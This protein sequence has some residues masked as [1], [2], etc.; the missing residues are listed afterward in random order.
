MFARGK[1]VSL[2]NQL[3]IWL[4]FVVL[5]VGLLFH[6]FGEFY[7]MF[8][9]FNL[10]FIIVDCIGAFIIILSIFFA[11][12]SRRANIK[13]F[14]SEIIIE[15]S[16]NFA[17]NFS[18]QALAFHYLFHNSNSPAGLG[19]FFVFV[20]IMFTVVGFFV[21]LKN[22]IIWKYK[23]I[24]LITMCLVPINTTLS[25]IFLTFTGSSDEIVEEGIS[26]F[27]LG[28]T[29]ILFLIILFMLYPKWKSLLSE[30]QNEEDDNEE[31]MDEENEEV[32]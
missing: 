4:G 9:T 18:F 8:R 6:F 32:E 1:I 11:F 3:I 25:G 2:K 13:E 12:Y 22:S 21:S 30:E 14:Q 20:A 29:S 15:T 17:L 24:V 5:F 23:V 19:V 10:L 28:L 31:G 7:P 26:V 16:L 27:F